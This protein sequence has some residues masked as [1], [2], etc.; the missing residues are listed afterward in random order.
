[1]RTRIA[2]AVAAATAVTFAAA[3]PSTAA[4]RLRFTSVDL[5]SSAGT[6]EPSVVV[7]AQGRIYASAIFGFP[8]NVTAPGTPVWRSV[9][10]GRTFTRHSTASAGPA[11]TALS[12]GDSALA[13]DKRGYV[14]ATDLWLG[15]DSISISTDHGDTWFG[16]P[17]SHRMVGDR[18][19]LAYA[20]KDDALYQIWNGVDGLYIARADLGTPLG[21]KAALS[22]TNNYRVAGE[23]VGVPG[24]YVRASTAWPGGLAVDQREG[25]VYAT[26]SDQDG[27]AI[28]RSGDQGATW[29][30]GHV[31]GTK[32]ATW[33][34]TAWNYAP[35][36][37]DAKGNVFV[38]WSQA[39]GG[40]ASPS[41][42][43]LYVGV[44]RD[45][46]KTW[47]K[48]KLG[49][50]RTAVFPSLALL[51][52][53][54]VAVAWV[55]ATPGGNPNDSGAFGGAMWRLAY[56]EVS[57]F[58]AGHA[59][60]AYATV[61]PYVHAGTV[62]VGTQGGNRAMGDFFSMA[63]GPGGQVVIAYTKSYGGAVSRVATL[64]G[65]R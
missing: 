12:G 45:G 35:V 10:K 33:V 32:G 6:T 18:N 41:A 23:T 48:T 3:G 54:R 26:W 8:G 16:S 4:P 22:F 43:S 9:D 17:V 59:R 31:T 1:M 52:N 24:S 63:V 2:A 60:T 65:R 14:Y 21:E 40:S 46:G 58:A 56:G 53:D 42:I 34:D 44:S 57:G 64:A 13:V 37:V 7:D 25:D 55:D 61:D 50:R 27:V 36:T 29:T 47:R 62:Y 49:T 51:G 15:D 39:I 28:G 38:A 20:T 19:W 11:A 5:P 30:I